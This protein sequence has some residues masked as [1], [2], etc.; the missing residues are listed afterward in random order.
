M[1]FLDSP[2]RVAHVIGFV[3]GWFLVDIVRAV[4]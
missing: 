1:D 3:I 4:L 2:V